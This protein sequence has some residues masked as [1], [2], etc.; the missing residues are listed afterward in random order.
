MINLKT[1]FTTCF[2]SLFSLIICAQVTFNRQEIDF[3]NGS[4]FMSFTDV[5]GDY[6]DDIIVLSEP[7]NTDIY[8]QTIN[9][10][11]RYAS[12]MVA[13][14]DADWTIAVA[15]YENDGTKEILTSGFYNGINKLSIVDP[16]SQEFETE[17][18]SNHL[19]FAQAS[20]S[21]DIDND[22][23]L[24]YFVCHDDGDSQ[25]YMNDGAGNLSLEVDRIPWVKEQGYDGSGNYGSIWIDIEQDGDLDLYIAKCRSFADLPTD[26]RRI[27]QLYINDGENNFTEQ[28]ADYN[29]AIGLQSWTADFGDMDN[30]G[31]LDCFITNHDGPHMLLQNNGSEGFSSIE[32]FA[33]EE[34]VDF[35]F[36]GFFSD[37]DNDG[38]LDII[39]VGQSN[40]FL[41]NNGNSTFTKNDLGF[42]ESLIKSCSVGDGN[43]DGFLDILASYTTGFTNSTSPNILFQNT[44]NDNNY[45]ALTLEGTTSNKDAVGSRVDAFG[46]WGLQ[47]RTIVSGSGYGVVNSVT[48]RYGLGEATTID[49]VIIYWPSGHIDRLY[50]LEINNHYQ[51]TEDLC[52]AKL[53]SGQ[54]IYKDAL[55]PDQDPAFVSTVGAL[56]NLLWNNGSDTDSIISLVEGFYTA[57]YNDVNGCAS[58][59]ETVFI[60]NIENSTVELLFESDVAC[61]GDTISFEALGETFISWYD[62]S[63]NEILEVTESSEVFYT[64]QGACDSIESAKFDVVFLEPETV[65]DSTV[66]AIIGQDVVIELPYENPLWYS[67]ENLENLVFEGSMLSILQ[68]EEDRTY[69]VTTREETNPVPVVVG[70]SLSD[71]DMYNSDALNNA[72]IFDLDRDILLQQVTIRTDRVGERRI[73][74]TTEDGAM[75]AF[76]DVNIET[77]GD[78]TLDL[79]FE[80]PAGKAYRLTTDSAVNI[81]VLGYESPRFARKEFFNS[82]PYLLSDYGQIVNS[83]QG[84]DY[85]YYF[86]DW[87]VSIEPVECESPAG[88]IN[89]NV[90]VS[91][92][93]D[94]QPHREPLLRPN[95]GSD[96]IEVLYESDDLVLVQIYNLSGSIVKTIVGSNNLN[97]SDLNMGIYIV[98]LDYKEQ[99]IYDRL[100]V[101]R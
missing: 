90:E 74:C 92:T 17:A 45:L 27:N 44:S 72:L 71:F 7:R 9:K 18:I 61:Q 35:A 47:T 58:K 57:T 25:V 91:S 43:D 13:D 36:Q 21:V 95:P 68:L 77:V 59:T 100:V 5:N 81:G 76:K 11:I 20:N 1:T 19:L 48:A 33:G 53:V 83:N 70:E 15:D 67:D 37:F 6:K 85:Y 80:I 94:H 97:V 14:G 89:V 24:D 99:T 32:L 10:S 16:V 4:M 64:A 26:K 12:S 66:E 88:E 63:Q 84:L 86:Y 75:I 34:L 50:D 42:S 62:G 23:F 82:Y 31:D 96:N 65:R 39:V 40:Y 54:L 38:F 73:I 28:A 78:H 29:L 8:L 93:K 3:P 87:V 98:R 49:S 79:D 56:D 30:D 41:W 55:C 52:S 22:G 46:S 51:V 101:Q 69:Y 60:G 2:I